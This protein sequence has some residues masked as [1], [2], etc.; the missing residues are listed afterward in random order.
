M[1]HNSLN[2][3]HNVIIFERRLT[4]FTEIINLQYTNQ[5]VIYTLSREQN[6]AA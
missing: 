2:K 1:Y 5:T 6:T 3:Y 4:N